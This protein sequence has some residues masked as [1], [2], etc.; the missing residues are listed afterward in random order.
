M[1]GVVEGGVVGEV[2]AA[3]MTGGRHEEGEA[4]AEED[5][6]NEKSVEVEAGRGGVERERYRGKWPTQ[7]KAEGLDP[8][9]PS[10]PSYHLPPWAPLPLALGVCE[11]GVG[12][13]ACGEGE[14][15]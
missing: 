6:V 3:E 10:P 1:W 13:C 8:C 15:E 9:A 12:A 2:G 14:R 11:P 7:G 5:G 4:H